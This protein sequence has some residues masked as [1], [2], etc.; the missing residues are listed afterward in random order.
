MKSQIFIYM[1]KTKQ[2]LNFWHISYIS[3][4]FN[5][6]RKYTFIEAKI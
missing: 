4:E 1:N 5:E 6:H 2:D 3:K